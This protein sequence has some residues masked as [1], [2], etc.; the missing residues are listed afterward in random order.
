MVRELINH[1]NADAH[2]ILRAGKGIAHKEVLAVEVV[3]NPSL[4]RGV[5]RFIK[6]NVHVSPPNSILG[7]AVSNDKAVFWCAPGKLAC[8]NVQNSVCSELSPIGL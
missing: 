4:K 8:E 2:G 5:E 3:Q 6:G 1:S 7:Q